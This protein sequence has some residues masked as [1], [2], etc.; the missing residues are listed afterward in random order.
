M[1]TTKTYVKKLTTKQVE[2]EAHRARK[3]DR[4]VRERIPMP[5]SQDELRNE[6]ARTTAV[7]PSSD[8]RVLFSD[9]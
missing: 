5:R 2:A 8:C 7:K 3:I 4:E 6:P 1:I 9:T